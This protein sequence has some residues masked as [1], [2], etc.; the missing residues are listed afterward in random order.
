MMRSNF[1]HGWSPR[2]V[3]AS[4][5]IAARSKKMIR[6]LAATHSARLSM[7]DQCSSSARL[8]MD[9]AATPVPIGQLTPVPP[10]PQ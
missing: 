2:R 4:D 3:D 10:R 8:R 9:Y 6:H 7:T 5:L 1:A